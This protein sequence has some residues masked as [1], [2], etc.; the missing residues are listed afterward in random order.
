MARNNADKLFEYTIHSMDYNGGFLRSRYCYW[1]KTL[2]DFQCSD[3]L[4]TIL[5]TLM[6]PFDFCD[7]TQYYEE[8][9]FAD[10]PFTAL[11]MQ[12]FLH[13]LSNMKHL[14]QAIHWGCGV[15]FRYPIKIDLVN[16]SFEILPAASLRTKMGADKGRNQ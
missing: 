10:S 9:D 16:E 4:K 12:I 8:G 1:E 6:T 11:K 13:D 2:S 15:G 7:S 14:E 5:I 3:N